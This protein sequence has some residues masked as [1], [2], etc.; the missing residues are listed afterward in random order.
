MTILINPNIHRGTKY[1]RQAFVDRLWNLKGLR[2]NPRVI[3]ADLTVY[4]HSVDSLKYWHSLSGIV[5]KADFAHID[6]Y[7]GV[8]HF[9]IEIADPL[10][11]WLSRS[12]IDVVLRQI[13]CWLA[14]LY[15]QGPSSRY[16]MEEQIYPPTFKELKKVFAE[17]FD[18]RAPYGDDNPDISE[19]YRD[20]CLG[21]YGS[22]PPDV[23]SYPGT[24]GFRRDVAESWHVADTFDIS[25]RRFWMRHS[26][27]KRIVDEGV[28]DDL[29]RSESSTE[30]FEA[31]KHQF[32][33]FDYEKTHIVSG[34]LQQ[35][36]AQGFVY[37]IGERGTTRYKIGFTGS[38]DVE[39]RRLALQT[40][41]AG[42]LFTAGAF[43]CASRSAEKVLHE[44]FAE[45]RLAGEWFALTNEQVDSILNEQWRVANAVF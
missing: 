10:Y 6:E 32:S 8:R 41:N 20:A 34:G 13:V 18:G 31:W 44:I 43:P 27:W 29:L 23:L 4:I 40:G 3:E 5:K 33:M 28:E 11:L 1:T 37:L 42:E 45:V 22:V 30:Y 39:K 7:F 14:A 12:D 15:A 26:D 36:S 25:I 19:I 17:Y 21:Y 35:A 2:S 38:E 9:G 24:L 16:I